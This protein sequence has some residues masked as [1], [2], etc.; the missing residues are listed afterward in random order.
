MENA[1]IDTQVTES[2]IATLLEN[3]KH[4]ISAGDNAGAGRHADEALALNEE[5]SDAYY[6][7]GAA[8][9][10]QKNIRKLLQALPRL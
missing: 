7:K 3:A 2:K 5:H 6:W 10:G 4:A 1:T 9:L 8:L